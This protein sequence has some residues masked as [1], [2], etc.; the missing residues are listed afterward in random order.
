M[1]PQHTNNRSPHTYPIQ[2][3][4]A[5]QVPQGIL[6]RL[7][8][9]LVGRQ[10]AIIDETVPAG[11]HSPLLLVLHEVPDYTPD[12]QGLFFWRDLD[13]IW[14]VYRQGQPY[15]DRENGIAALREHL[16]NYEAQEE[17]L[18]N[19]YERARRAAQYLTILEDAALQC[20]AAANLHRTLSDA[21]TLMREQKI[22]H[23]VEI[24]NAR[25]RAYNIER[26]FDLLY[27]DTQNA[28]DYRE[29]H[30]VE[31]LNALFLIFF[32]LT[33]IASLFEMG[34]I[35][36]PLTI[37][38]SFF[39]MGIMQ[40]LRQSLPSLDPSLIVSALLL[41]GL[42]LGFGFYLL[43]RPPGR[44]RRQRSHRR[45]TAQRAPRQSQRTVSTDTQFT[46]LPAEHAP[47]A[48]GARSP[49]PNPLLRSSSG[50]PVALE[51]GMK[52]YEIES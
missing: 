48:V 15:N 27:T 43:I 16:A 29:A 42:L 35:F 3:P 8:T 38:A 44:R 49:R 34:V 20:H 30:V 11:I 46:V 41:G 47:A 2:L 39:E 40:Q 24:I 18:R 4:A 12:R 10:R 22:H 6:D 36:F 9:D 52:Q 7:G 31:I 26:E 33:I 14:R 51:K 50:T 21:R 28:L 13:G 25:D 45:R 23:D 1:T 37:I 32:P 19:A 17:A 5:W